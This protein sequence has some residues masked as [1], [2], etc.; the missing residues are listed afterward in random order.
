LRDSEF[1]IF[2][3]VNGSLD[4]VILR[5]VVD[6]EVVHVN[7]RVSEGRNVAHLSGSFPGATPLAVLAMGTLLFFL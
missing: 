7:A 2:G 5:G 1:V 3:A 6:G 4:R